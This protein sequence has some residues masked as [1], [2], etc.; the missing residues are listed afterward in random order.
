MDKYIGFDIHDNKTVACILEKGKKDIYQTIPTEIPAMKAWLKQQRNSRAKLHLTFEVSGSTGWFYDELRGSVD[1]LTVSNPSKMTWI[2][3]TSKKTDRIDAFKQAMLLKMGEIPSVHI[4]E[5]EVRQ[6][7]VQIQH[8]RKLVSLRTQVKNRVRMLLKSHGYRQPASKGS[9]W[10]KVNRQWMMGLSETVLDCWAESLGDLLDQLAM[11]EGQIEH[12]SKKLDERLSKHGGGGLLQTIPGV[13]PRTAEAV[14]AYTDD[15]S[16]FARGK[17]YCGYFGMTPK[18]DESGSTRR[19]GHISKQGPSVVRW[20]I[21]ESAWRA[22]RKSPALAEFF[23]R[24]TRGQPKRKKVA[25]VATARKMLSVMRAMLMTGE[26]FNE[27]LVLRQEQ[28]LSRRMK[29]DF[30]N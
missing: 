11:Y 19:V 21:V 10:K 9:W 3:R 22:I 17:D 4:P 25:V 23:G 29:A 6:W 14:L 28:C 12:R 16:R 2:F 27:Q 5:K 24:V 30:Y 13:G 26:V 20:L 15:V 8:R 1:S 7:R 18:L